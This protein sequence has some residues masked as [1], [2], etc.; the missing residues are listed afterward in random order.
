MKMFRERNKLPIGAVVVA[1]IVLVLVAVLRVNTLVALYGRHYDAVFTEAGGLQAGSSVI[2][3]GVKVGRVDSVKL[4]P[5]G[6]DVRFALTNGHV[7]LGDATRADIKV[8]TILG[9]KALVLTS[10]GGGSLASGDT[11]PVSRTTAPY[12]VTTALSQLTTETGQIDISEVSQALDTVSSTLSA[13]APQLHD[14]LTGVSRLSETVASRDGELQTLLAHA[15]QFSA[16]LADRGTT[17]ASLVSDG[18]QLMSS[19]VDRRQ[20]ITDLLSKVTAMATQLSGL[21]DDNEAQ[22]RPTLAALNQVIALLEKNKDNLD[23]TIVGA[24]HYVTT[25]GESVSSGPFFEAILGN[26]LPANLV[27]DL[28]TVTKGGL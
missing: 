16:I 4:A 23:K 11:I 17:I 15:N 1:L 7:S 3:S 25:F 18:N 12:D 8:N 28:Q 27:P 20:V 19:L 6:V 2:V 13:S 22:L 10:K 24:S 26:L 5:K 14:A 9:E 21:V